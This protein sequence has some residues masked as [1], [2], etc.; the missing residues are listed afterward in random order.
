M[1]GRYVY[2]NFGYIGVQDGDTLNLI[3]DAGFYFHRQR[4][5]SKKGDPP[6]PV[7]YRLARINAP[8]L[9]TPEGQESKTALATLITDVPIKVETLPDP[10]KYGRFLIEV[11][12]LVADNW[13]NVNDAMV[14]AGRAQY[15]SY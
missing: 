6:R 15:H 7:G 2:E 1:I 13:I 10:E 3:I 9:S 5:P 14:A 11:Q 8:E 12:V 4:R